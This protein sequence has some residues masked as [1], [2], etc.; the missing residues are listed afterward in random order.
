[1]TEST[2]AVINERVAQQ[3]WGI[4][5]LFACA[6]QSCNVGVIRH[7]LFSRHSTTSPDDAARDI[8]Y[9]TTFSTLAKGVR[10]LSQTRRHSRG[11]RPGAYGA[12]GDRCVRP[13][14]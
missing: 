1:M 4:E 3:V 9:V 12:Q 6:H 11:P 10:D 2:L 14:T 8:S 13:T 7:G 5:V